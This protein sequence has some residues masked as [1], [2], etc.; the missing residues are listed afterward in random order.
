MALKLLIKRVFLK[1]NGFYNNAIFL[2]FNGRENV[3]RYPAFV[4]LSP[5]SGCFRRSSWSYL[6]EIAIGND[7]DDDVVAF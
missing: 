2:F 5:R 1:T 7:D 3:T 4:I 6:T